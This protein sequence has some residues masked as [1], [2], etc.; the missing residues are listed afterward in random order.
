MEI[1]GNN[2]ITIQNCNF[3]DQALSTSAKPYTYEAIQLDIL[4][5]SH[6]SGYLSEDLPLKNVKITGCSFKNVPRGIGSH[7]AILNN[8]VDTIEISNNTFTSLKSL[9]IQAMNYINCTITG[10]TITDTPQGIMI[11]S[12]RESGTFLASTAV[13][14]G[15]IPSSTPVTYQTPVNNQKWLSAIIQ[16][17]LQV[18]TLM[19]ITK[20]PL[21]CQWFKSRFCHYRLW[22]YNSCR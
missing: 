8:P 10:N 22:R 20:M 21:F 1:A 17:Q 4:L 19:K 18:M 15:H 12:V 16:L 5:E 9:A 2:G 14:E 11:Y 7:T 13:K 3:A 6:L